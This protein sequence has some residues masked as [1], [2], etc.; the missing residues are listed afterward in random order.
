M[1]KLP[2]EGVRIID[3]TYVVAMPY[4]MG[5]ATDLG[6]E[7]VKI[8]GP[9][10]VD[11]TRGVGTRPGPDGLQGDGDHWNRAVGFNQMNRGK[12]S[13]TLDLSRPEGREVFIE[14]VRVSDVVVDNYTPRV[15]RRWGL[16]Y[17]NL[18]KVKPDLVMISNTAYGYGEGPYSS[19]PG[20]ATT[21]EAT[22]GLAWITGYQGDIPGKAGRSYVDFLSAWSGLFALATALRRRNRTGRGQWIDLAMYQLACTFVGEYI[23]DYVANGRVGERMGNRHPWRLQ[24]CYPCADDDQWC[25]LSVGDD[26]EWAALCASMDRPDLAGDPRY[27]TALRRRTRQDDL[28]CEIAAWTRTLPKWD[29]AH[30]LQQAGIPCGPVLTTGERMLDEHAWAHGFLEKVTAPPERGL[31]TRVL[32]G[33]PYRMSKAPARIRGFAPALGDGNDHYLKG[34]LDISSRRIAELEAKDVVNTVPTQV[35]NGDTRTAQER[36]GG[37]M[38]DARLDPDYKAKLGI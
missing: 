27:A 23:T 21:M 24:G 18:R 22:H 16:D 13:L 4:A 11:T 9:A 17:P 30:R 3:S 7:V 26:A 10:H 34:V 5:M 14:L 20:Q 25:V 19:Y 31:G 28:D 12:R 29:A 2:L 35:R 15:M 37:G 38:V 32:M 1:A 6:A 33:R 36:G 8:E